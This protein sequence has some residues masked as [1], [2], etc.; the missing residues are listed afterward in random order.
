MLA[1]GRPARVD[2]S[3]TSLKSFRP[4]G[5]LAEA[6]LLRVPPRR[7]HGARAAAGRRG[8]P[9]PG[10]S[11]ARPAVERVAL[12][13]RGARPPAA[14]PPA[15]RRRRRP[16]RPAPRR[17][18]RA[19]IDSSSPWSTC[20][21]RPRRPAPAMRPSRPRL[22]ARRDAS[23]QVLGAHRAGGALGPPGGACVRTRPLPAS[24][25]PSAR[26]LAPS[27]STPRCAGSSM[28]GAA[29]RFL[30]DRAES[31][32]GVRIDVV[33]ARRRRHGRRAGA[34]RPRQ[35]E[36]PSRRLLRHRR[37]HR[38]RLGRS[39]RRL[40]AVADVAEAYNVP[41]VVNGSA[42]LL[43]VDDLADVEKL[44]NKAALF[45]PPHQAPWRSLSRQAGA[46][47]G[48][49]RAATACSRAPRTTRPP[50]ACARPPSKSFPTTQAP[51]VAPARVRHRRAHAHELPRDRLA[52][53]HP[54][55]GSRRRH[56]AEPARPP[57]KGEYEGEE[58]IAIPT[59]AFLSTDTQRE[60]G[61]SGVLALASA[62]NSDA[63][64]V[65]SA[66]TAYVTPPK[67]TYDSATTEPEVRLERV[68]LADQLFVARLAQF[69]RA[70]C[71]KMPHDERSGR[72]EAVL[73]GALWELFEGAAAREHR[74]R[75][76][77]ERAGR[78]HGRGR[79]GAA[80]PLPRRA[81][82][83]F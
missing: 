69:L 18:R 38:R 24:R 55:R 12:R 44:D 37:P 80:A 42:E 82:R 20:R 64:Y 45:H 61:R 4:D 27:S 31:H 7:A 5:L 48:G 67:R 17:R 49:H 29:L 54:R 13:A 53:P 59:E 52:V 65:L 39:L 60:L 57:V 40:E 2:L 26:R 43:G 73:E 70:L 83:R 3:P 72:G 30:A 36:R 79:H 15:P 63:V 66:P 46:A 22:P 19:S 32:A 1:E 71:S 23:E 76:E 16:P 9:R 14:G 75:R 10:G 78:G 21:P 33:N 74:A 8:H 58:G 62:P 11:R 47:L 77:G 25:R 35:H 28:R 50:R 68:S 41:V 81:S 51:S 56:G 34:R 6:P